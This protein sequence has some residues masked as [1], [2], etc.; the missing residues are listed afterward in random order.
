MSSL[1]RPHWLNQCANQALEGTIAG[2][3]RSL[4]RAS[5]AFAPHAAGHRCG[6]YAAE[7]RCGGIAELAGDFSGDAARCGSYEA[8]CGGYEARCGMELGRGAWQDAGRRLVA[9]Q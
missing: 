4:P 5:Q 6:M 2:I 1:Q 3:A 7:S 8:R 9:A